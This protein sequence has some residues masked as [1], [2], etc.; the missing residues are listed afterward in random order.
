MISRRF[1]EL[2]MPATA[3]SPASASRNGVWRIVM[4]ILSLPLVLG[5]LLWGASVMSDNNRIPGMLAHA[6]KESSVMY[7]TAGKIVYGNGSLVDRALQ[8]GTFRC[9]EW[10]MRGEQTDTVRGA[11][12]WPNSP[13]RLNP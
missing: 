9:T 5:G 11:A 1:L 4:L 3:I 13:R 2:P 10:K 7:C 8:P 12:P 6:A